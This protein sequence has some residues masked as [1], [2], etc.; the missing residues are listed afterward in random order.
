MP[1]DQKMAAYIGI[2]IVQAVPMMEKAF[3]EQEKNLPFGPAENRSGYMVVYPDGYES[4]S[5]KDTFEAAYR[6]ISDDERKLL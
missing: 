6:L 4:W 3:V 2:K 1:E 5:P